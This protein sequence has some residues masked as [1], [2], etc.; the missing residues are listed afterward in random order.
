MGEANNRGGFISLAVVLDVVGGST[1]L[2]AF[3]R[4]RLVSHNTG[5]VALI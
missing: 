5:L 3:I 4:R 1:P 2:C